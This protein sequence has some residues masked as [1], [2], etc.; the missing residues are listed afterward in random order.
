MAKKIYYKIGEACKK[1]DIQPYVLRYWETEFPFLSPDK[2][3][4]GQRAYGEREIEIIARI[5]ELLY[6]EG[7]TIAG[8]KKR[9]ETELEEG[10]GSLPTGDAAPKAVAKP[11]TPSAAD[12]ATSGAAKK[13]R[14]KLDRETEKTIKTLRAGIEEGIV[15]AREILKLIGTPASP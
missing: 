13:E 11:A 3:K 4:S 1:L 7:Y 6:D 14:A 9:L 15:Q 10:G 5:K 12:D 8:A 2:S